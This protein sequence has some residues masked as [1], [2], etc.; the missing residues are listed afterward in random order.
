MKLPKLTIKKPDV[1]SPLKTRSFRAGGYSV[2]AGIIVLAIAVA[3][4]ILVNAL[5]DSMTTF[6]TTANQVFSI[7]EQTENLLDSLKSEIDVYWVVQ[8]GKEDSTLGTLL[9]R[10]TAMSDKVHLEKKDPD[11][12][13]TFIQQYTDTVRNNSLIVESGERYRYV[14]YNEIYQY[15]Y[16]DDYWYS[17]TSNVNFAGESAITSAIDYVVSSTLPKV[18]TLTGH[19]ESELASPF[20]SAVE[21][22]NI[23]LAELS[24]LTT[25]AVPEDADCVMVYAP[26]SDISE[27]E[28]DMLL[29]YLQD[30]GNMLLITNPP[31][32]GSLTN[33]EA[34]MEY[35]NVTATEGIV[36]EGNQNNFAWGTPYYL[37][38]ELSA[39]TITS[40]LTSS[41]YRVMLPISQGLKI[42]NSTRDTVTVTELL[43]T[44]DDAFSKTAGYSLTTYEKEDGDLDG[45]FSLAVAVTESIDEENET[46]IV[47]ISSASLLD[48]QANMQVS[49]GNQDFFLNCLNWM[50][51]PDESGITIHAK[52]MDYEYLTIDSGTA[53]LLTFLIIAVIPL[54]YLGTGISIWAR[55]KRR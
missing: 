18:Y 25:D 50:C 21:Q 33:L 38:P 51:E 17:G 31:K 14:D 12:Y 48:S 46:Q 49:G 11:V 10:Y 16:G 23:E 28:R 3:V 36:V 26:Q 30:G 37:L 15:E 47:W 24:L 52:S 53:S 42:G 6:D 13:P 39:H 1:I 40:P 35:Y 54:A 44:S 55:R 8:S 27:S 29:T 7:S 19:G 2:S 22:E 20:A 34:V 9:D 32:E 4:N 5:P 41:G 45:P 43:A